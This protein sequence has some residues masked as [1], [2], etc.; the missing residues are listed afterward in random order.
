[1]TAKKLTLGEKIDRAIESEGRKQVWIIARM[2]EKGFDTI[3]DTTFSQKKKGHKEFTE[4][5]LT[6]LSEI[7]NVELA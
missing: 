3:T 5:E 6:A 2:N 1:M 4:L 7:L